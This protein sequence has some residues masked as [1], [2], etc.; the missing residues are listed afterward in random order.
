MPDDAATFSTPPDTSAMAR[1]T[2]RATSAGLGRTRIVLMVVALVVAV[3]AA[4]GLF[5]WW[6]VGRFIQ[7]TNDAYLRAD[8]V[9]VA[10]K[11]QGYVT[12]VLVSDNQQVAAGQPLVRIDPRS[13]QAGAQQAQATIDAR[14]ADL[15]AARAQLAQQQ[16]A[17][18]QARAQLASARS[19]AAF[20]SGEVERYRP[21]AASG[22]D[23]PEKLQQLTN[24]RDQARQTVVANGAAVAGA[25]RQVETL[26]AQIS[27]AGAQLEA[28]RANARQV[29][30]NLQDTVL[31][32]A[33]AGRVGDKTVQLG[34]Y[35]AAGARLMTI[36]P[37]GSIYLVA[38]F[39]ETQIGRMRPGQPVTIHVD[40]L[41]GK[42]LKGV[43][44]SF[45][46]GT[47]AQFALLPPENA[48]G[49]FTKIVQRMPVR[50]RVQASPE[51]QKVLVPGLSATASIDTRS[52]S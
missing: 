15:A 39:K 40:A 30:L 10:P 50:I 45:A 8:Q 46:P 51:A 19:G 22:A 27:Q 44:D 32:S 23:T 43:V 16:A 26:E 49:N 20:A 36:V 11:V 7:S 35:V 13:Y 34:Q 29:G 24:S 4:V 17:I 42:V 21:L 47:G 1:P 12:Q 9:V 41:G 5:N 38:N 25:E 31:T 14:A 48:T 6:T 3:A 37:T 52:A 18:A 33:I 28:A 2:G